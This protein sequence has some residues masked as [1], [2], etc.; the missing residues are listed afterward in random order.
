MT[1]PLLDEEPLPVCQHDAALVLLAETVLRK[2]ARPGLRIAVHLNPRAVGDLTGTVGW[3][4]FADRTHALVDDVRV[5]GVETETESI[6]PARMRCDRPVAQIEAQ[7]V[8][9]CRR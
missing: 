1:W 4:D 3:R 8:H 5:A 9:V 7:Q 2:E 6:D